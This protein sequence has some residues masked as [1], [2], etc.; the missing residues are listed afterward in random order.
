[1][2][3]LVK[4]KEKRGN[5]LI[6]I[7]Y[8]RNVFNSNC[9]KCQT[10]VVKLEWYMALNVCFFLKKHFFSSIAFVFGCPHFDKIPIGF[11][12]SFSIE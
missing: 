9:A 7:F 2:R 3:N 6:K 4:K 5:L 10:G 11:P 8:K 1:M 12:K